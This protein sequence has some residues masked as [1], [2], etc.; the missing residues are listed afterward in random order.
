MDILFYISSSNNLP[1]DREL[2]SQ[3]LIINRNDNRNKVCHKRAKNHTFFTVQYLIKLQ[4]LMR[5]LG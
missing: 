2:N 1:I 5:R 3:H 4:N